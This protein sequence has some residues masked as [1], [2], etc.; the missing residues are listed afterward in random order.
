LASKVVIAAGVIVSR[1]SLEKAAAAELSSAGVNWLT[2]LGQG[3][4]NASRFPDI[5]EDFTTAYHSKLG[6]L[7]TNEYVAIWEEHNG[8]RRVVDID[9]GKKLHFVDR[10]YRTTKAMR[11]T[12]QAENGQ[13]RIQHGIAKDLGSVRLNPNDDPFTLDGKVA[14]LS[15]RENGTALVLNTLDPSMSFQSQDLMETPAN[16][17]VPLSQV[18]G[19][20][21]HTPFENSWHR[22]RIFLRGQ[23]LV[24]ENEAPFSWNLYPDLQNGVLRTDTTN[25]YFDPAIPATQEF[26]LN[27]VNG[28]VQGFTFNFSAFERIGD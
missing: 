24:W 26:K 21:E 14:F 22:G 2:D 1:S 25:P 23:Q 6:K 5:D 12:L 27:I 20:Y 17:E 8:R 15:Y 7:S 9:E 19:T 3:Y 28:K 18:I 10:E 11:I 4:A 16:P 13:V